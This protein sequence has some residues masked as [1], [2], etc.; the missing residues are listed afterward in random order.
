M[1]MDSPLPTFI[2]LFISAGDHLLMTFDKLRGK[3]FIVLPGSHLY[4]FYT[5]YKRNN[6]HLFQQHKK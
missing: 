4:S 1:L 5:L 6:I 3:V 2:I